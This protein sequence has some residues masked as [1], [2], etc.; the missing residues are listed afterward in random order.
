M[1]LFIVT[2]DYIVLTLAGM[3]GIILSIGM[4]V[5]ANVL[6]FERMKEELRKGKLLKTAAHTGFERAWPSIR[7]GNAS[8][9]ITCSILFLVGT[10]IVRGFAITLGIGVLLSMLTPSLLRAG[11]LGNW[12]IQKSRTQHGCLRATF[13][14]RNE[15]SNRASLHFPKKTGYR[16]RMPQVLIGIGSNIDAEQNLRRCAGLLRKAWPAIRFSA[17]FRTEAMLGDQKS[18]CLNAAVLAQT[19]STPHDVFQKRRKSRS[20]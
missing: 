20:F 9:F 16:A 5:D 18:L 3:A 6:I 4:A 11:S 13:Q 17:V 2:D 12:P 10:S 7:D 15:K 1:P 19:E 14:S 8:T